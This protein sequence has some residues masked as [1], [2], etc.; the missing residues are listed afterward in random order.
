MMKIS[1]AIISLSIIF[2]STLNARLN[3]FIPTKTYLEEKDALLNVSPTVKKEE[4]IIKVKEI[5]TTKAI[6]PIKVKKPVEEIILKEPLK[7]VVK[8]K[9]ITKIVLKPRE[10]KTYKYNLLPFVDI[11]ITDDI[12]N[13][14]TKY[15][16]KKHFILKDEN[17]LVF[18]YVGKK[19]FYTKR[20]TLSSHNDFKKIIIGA[21]PEN[22][23]F[24]VVIQTQE[25]V[26]KYKVTING[27]ITIVKTTRK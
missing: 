15:K 24:R 16:L 13:L 25:D 6:V 14:H 19:R 18:D 12:M 5:E 8:D 11:H 3:P 10:V 9:N 26:S 7:L 22:Y 17:K 27:L 21:H 1:L 20:E 2:T 4:P 23:Y